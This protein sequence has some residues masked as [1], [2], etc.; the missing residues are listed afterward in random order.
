MIL[1][2]GAPISPSR[3]GS[4]T[5]NPASRPRKAYAA[6]STSLGRAPVS[7][8]GGADD[9]LDFLVPRSPAELT[10]GD[11]C[12]GDERGGIAQPSRR[13]AIAH[14]SPGRG[15]HCAHDLQI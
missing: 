10:V 13:E 15:L 7:D 1:H 14:R 12:V 6:R 3:A 8:D 11:R 4:W 5:G 2:G 9:L